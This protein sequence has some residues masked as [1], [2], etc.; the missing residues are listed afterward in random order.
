MSLAGNSK[1]NAKAA[2]LNRPARIKATPRPSK[3]I[4]RQK[5][6]VI[7]NILFLALTYEVELKTTLNNQ[8]INIIG[9]T[10]NSKMPISESAKLSNIAPT[11]YNKTPQK[12]PANIKSDFFF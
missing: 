4:I 6:K 5:A 3:M 12:T 10:A 7:R 9:I 8:T 11:K 2:E 1:T